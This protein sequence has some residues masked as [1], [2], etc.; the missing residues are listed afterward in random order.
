MAERQMSLGSFKTT[1]PAMKLFAAG[2]LDRTPSN[3]IPR[4]VISDNL[5]VRVQILVKVY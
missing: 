2:E 4:L 3:C 5:L 1:V